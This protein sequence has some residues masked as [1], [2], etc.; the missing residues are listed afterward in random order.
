MAEST[1]ISLLKDEYETLVWET[2]GIPKE[3]FSRR[4][5]DRI[6]QALVFDADWT[7]KAANELLYLA[8]RYGT[9]MLRNACAL[10]MALEIED[11]DAGF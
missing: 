2:G 6:R 9:F 7:P 5:L 11:G 1:D 3:S 4:R 10:S 8:T